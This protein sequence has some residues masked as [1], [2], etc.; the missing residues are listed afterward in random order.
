[1]DRNWVPDP[2]DVQ[3]IKDLPIWIF[4]GDEDTMVPVQGDDEVFAALKAVGGRVRYT[5]AA[6]EGHSIHPIAYYADATY[7]WLLQQKKGLPQQP[8]AT[9]QSVPATK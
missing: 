1:L 7:E 9:P 3:R 6:G 8:P 5:R 2:R 4:H